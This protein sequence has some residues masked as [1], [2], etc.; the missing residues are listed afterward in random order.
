METELKVALQEAVLLSKLKSEFLTNISH[1]LRTP[2]NGIIG[3]AELLQSAYSEPLSE[4][5]AKYVRV[6]A[7]SGQH[8]LSLVNDV[9]DLARIEEGRMR[10]TPRPVASLKYRRPSSPGG[11]S[12]PSSSRIMAVNGGSDLPTEP[13]FSSHSSEEMAQVVPTSD[14]P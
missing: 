13:G 10:F 12:L 4:Q 8:L 14:A 11:S 3:F 7:D 2:L 6:I 1:E 9:L 5:Q